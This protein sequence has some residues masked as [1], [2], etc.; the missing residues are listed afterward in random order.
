MDENVDYLDIM[1]IV[2]DSD[3]QLPFPHIFC[4]IPRSS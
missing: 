1:K 3:T 4:K 2:I